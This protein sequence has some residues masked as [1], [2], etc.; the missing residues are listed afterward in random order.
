M[1]E[2]RF[3]ILELVD[4]SDGE[5][6]YLVSN[7][8]ILIEVHDKEECAIKLK[9]ILDNAWWDY[10]YIKNENICNIVWRIPSSGQ[11]SFKLSF[12]LQLLNGDS[13]LVIL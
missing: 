10:D 2:K 3:E 11:Y 1:N 5:I 13:A 9:E 6:S 12:S 7:G 8:E 4:E